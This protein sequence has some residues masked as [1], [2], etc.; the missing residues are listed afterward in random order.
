MDEK[1]TVIVGRNNSGKTSFSEVIRRF[2]QGSSPSFGLEDFSAHCFG[3]FLQA[4]KDIEKGSSEEEVRRKIPLIELRLHYTYDIETIGELSDFLIDLNKES[5]EIIVVIRYQLKDGSIG[6]FFKD[7]PTSHTKG[8]KRRLFFREISARIETFYTTRIFAEDPNNS[9]NI[10]EEKKEILHKILETNFISAHRKLEENSRQEKDEL[11]KVVH[12]LFN[13]SAQDENENENKKAV[14]SIEKVVQSMQEM[15]DG[16]FRKNLDKLLTELEII[17][18]HD[19]KSNLL[20]TETILR[21]EKLLGDHTTVR[22]DGGAG[23][24][25]PESSNGLGMRNFIFILLKIVKFYREFR[26]KGN[27]GRGQVIFVEEPES[28]LHPQLQQVFIKKIQEMICNLEKSKPTN[29]SWPVQIV[30]TTHSPHIANDIANE[31]DFSSIRY[32][33]RNQNANELDFHHTS[34]KDLHELQTIRPKKKRLM[35][36][37]L[38]KYMTLTKCDL[39]FADKV[40]LVEGATERFFIPE[41]IKK[42]MVNKSPYES[43]GGQYITVIES[44]GAHAHL[45]FNLLDFLKIRTLVISDLD[46]VSQKSKT[47]KNV[48]NCIVQDATATN[49]RCIKKWLNVKTYK[50]IDLIKDYPSGVE[51]GNRKLVFQCPEKED[52]PCGRTFEDAFILANLQTFGITGSNPR[53]LEKNAWNEAQKSNDKVKFALKHLQSGNPWNTPR[54]IMEGLAWLDSDV[55]DVDCIEPSSADKTTGKSNDGRTKD[56]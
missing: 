38:R 17:D 29:S 24:L 35:N 46:P 54:Y 45:F 41:M 20:T 43:L 44:G 2:F 7:I 4:Y 49:C 34:V 32:F 11:S 1:I 28:H 5:N 23:I 16:D 19:H 51:T 10:I 31:S 55:S 6:D 53:E 52:G 47:D 13:I 15:I 27:S 56:E 42:Y 30:I 21:T 22:Y 9:S 37:D 50:P 12:E 39:Y 8:K 26:S 33:F 25:L 14:I 40:I 36:D 18:Y 48:V 3:D